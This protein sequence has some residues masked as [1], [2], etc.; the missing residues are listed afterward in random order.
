MS[1]ETVHAGLAMTNREALG[2][3][4]EMSL[5][6]LRRLAQALD[7]EQKIIRSLIREKARRPERAVGAER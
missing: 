1:S 4:A 6:D 3:L 2:E 7:V 5:D